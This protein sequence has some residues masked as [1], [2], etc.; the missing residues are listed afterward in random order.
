MGQLSAGVGGATSIE[1][2]VFDD[3]C[4]DR[5]DVDHLVPP[6]RRIRSRQPVAAAGI[7][8]RQM[9]MG[10]LAASYRLQLWPSSRLAWLSV[11]GGMDT[12]RKLLPIRSRRLATS[13]ARAVSW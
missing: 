7:G 8:A 9:I 5:R 12:L 3:L 13:A 6:G 10:D 1:Q 2:A 4:P 11:E